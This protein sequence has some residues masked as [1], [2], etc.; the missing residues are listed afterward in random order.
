MAP[1][2]DPSVP[3]NDPY[4]DSTFFYSTT[5]AVAG[6]AEFPDVGYVQTSAATIWVYAAHTGYNNSPIVHNP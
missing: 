6:F 3:A 1:G 5:S 2:Y 4:Q